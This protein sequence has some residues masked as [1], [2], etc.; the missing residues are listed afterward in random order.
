M[1]FGNI[2]MADAAAAQAALEPLIK[3][4]KPTE[5]LLAKPPFKFLYDVIVSLRE[6]TG[7]PD[8]LS[9]D[10][11]SAVP[12]D[13]DAKIAFLQK[14]I[15]ATAAKTGATLAVKPAKVTAGLEPEN[16][17]AWLV[18]LANAATQHKAAA[19][20]PAKSSKKKASK[21]EAADD[22]GGKKKSSKKGG[23]EPA[24]DKKKGKK[25]DK[26]EK[27]GDDKKKG[28]KKGAEKEEKGGKKGSKKAATE[29][30]KPKKGKSKS[31]E[32]KAPEPEPEEPAAPPPPEPEPEPSPKADEP[33]PPPP[34]EAAPPPP[35]AEPKGEE[36]AV[37]PPRPQTARP[38]PPRIQSN[39]RTVEKTKLDVNVSQSQA[40]GLIQDGEEED[41][42]SLSLG[43]DD[44][45]LEADADNKVAADLD[46]IDAEQAGGL[47]RKLMD[48]TKG[49]QEE[50]G[51]A[52]RT[53]TKIDAADVSLATKH[54]KEQLQKEVA[55]LRESIQ[56]VCRSAV[57]LG[58]TMDYVQ[59]DF[60]N[61][62]K[63]LDH[64]KSESASQ[65]DR[66]ESEQKATELALQPLYQELTKLET[67]IKE[68]QRKVNQAKSNVER[69][70]EHIAK[71]LR[72]V[73]N[74]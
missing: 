50:G 67:T 38:P 70:D 65:L 55:A 14:C 53:R 42:E 21:E 52:N 6:A 1:L 51:G 30:E 28:S 66:F 46:S 31:K 73:V 8:V 18:E 4:P 26:A 17:C 2:K 60:E 33:P 3:K 16:T 68:V 45:A 40:A 72:M 32:E 7:F 23:D 39:V 25:G 56:V 44:D 43:D 19:E 49:L 36:K 12:E 35:P 41:E 13:K 48:E 15:D 11:L 10:D 22:G 59:E 74:R 9:P 34:A 47:V 57:P 5:K 61:M 20:A 58:K 37:P 29:E 24:E 54:Q 71:L 27:G 64:W 63:E 69:N 62:T